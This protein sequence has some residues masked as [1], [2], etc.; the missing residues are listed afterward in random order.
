MKPG[1]LLRLALLPLLS[2]TLVGCSIHRSHQ[3]L[4]TQ[5]VGF[6]LTV[7]EAQNE[8]LLLNVIRAKDRLPMYVT[9]VSSLNG[10]LSSTLS[11]GLGGSY[12]DTETNSSTSQTASGGTLPTALETVTGATTKA[13]T[14]GLVPSLGGTLSR[15]P[16]FSLSVLDGEKFMRGF[17]SPIEPSTIAY[18]WD[19][20]WPRE[21]LFYLLV[22]RVEFEDRPP[23]ENHPPD[24]DKFEDFAA[25]VVDFL[26]TDRQFVH[27][28][29]LKDFGPRLKSDDV[30]SLSDLVA[31]SKEGLVLTRAGEGWQLQRPSSEYCIRSSDSKDGCQRSGTESDQERSRP[32]ILTVFETDDTGVEP[33]SRL[34]LRSPEGMLYYLGQLM[35]VANRQI[36]PWIPLVCIQGEH[37]PLF[38]ALP[39]GECTGSLVAA[40]SPGGDFAIPPS[41]EDTLK[42][43]CRA[44][45]LSPSGSRDRCD[46]GRSMQALRLLSQLISLQKSA[47]ELP[48]PALVRVIGE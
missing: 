45:E 42:S 47:D 3:R 13:I 29:H 8:M 40:H 7:E 23:L 34:V 24:R 11:A 19:Q 31:T 9:T 12:A 48:T 44:G 38:V 18:Y 37:R 26:A 27:G 39:L 1:K 15:N 33:P 2:L 17:L 16:N 22:H 21:L 10:N 25:W 36:D 4:A 5:A 30:E 35:R 32:G 41:R 43:G 28:T 14:R 46:S 20:G 6:N